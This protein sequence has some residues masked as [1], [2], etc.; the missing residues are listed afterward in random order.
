MSAD[1]S[2]GA[3]KGTDRPPSGSAVQLT[4]DLDWGVRSPAP[5][6]VPVPTG[7]EAEWDEGLPLVRCLRELTL[8]VARK[9][10]V[11]AH[12]DPERVAFSLSHARNRSRSGTYAFIVPL[13]FEGGAAETK[14]GRRTYR[15]PTVT[16]GDREALYLVY[17]LAPRFFDLPHRRK[18]HTVLHE[19]YH[20][21]P[22]FDGD[23]R[24]F[25]GRR[26]AHGPSREKYDQTV[27]GLTEL[28]LSESR[29]AWPEA[30]E[31]LRYSYKDCR[32]LFGG[33]R[34]PVIPRPHPVAI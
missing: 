17:F 11:L 33:V 2:R 24:R 13:R 4:L 10:P 3:G 12:V 1:S 25:P 31:F 29:G 34:G 28:Y 16:L 27:E 22:Q 9:V 14:Y 5:A 8:D 21:S 23:L 7:R 6:A 26:W 30:A 18:L 20:I 15:M 19:L 32:R